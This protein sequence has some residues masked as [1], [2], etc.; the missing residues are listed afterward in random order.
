MERGVRQPSDQDLPKLARA[1]RLDASDLGEFF[2]A[3]RGLPAPPPTFEHLDSFTERARKVLMLAQEE[4]R[5][6]NHNYFG[7]E[8]LLLGLVR[9]GDGVAARVLNNMGMYLPKLRAAI[10]FTI[11]RGAAAAVDNVGPTPRT[12]KVITLAAH[13]ARRLNHRGIDTE[14]L[15]L[16]L[17]REG[18]GIAA[19]VLDTLGVDREQVREQVLA[20]ISSS[21]PEQPESSS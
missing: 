15:L 21:E 9:E 18:E 5:L 10:N 11:G 8:H 16:A 20:T 17:A 1:L 4:R 3:G 13:E 12:S 6:F 19:G 14:H 7:T 2:R